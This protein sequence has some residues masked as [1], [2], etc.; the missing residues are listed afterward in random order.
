MSSIFTWQEVMLKISKYANI[1]LMNIKK[2]SM[3]R[4]VNVSWGI[5][6]LCCTLI[7]IAIEI[8][9]PYFFLRDDNADSFIADYTYGINCISSGRFPF[10]CFNEFG[11]QRFFAAGQTGIFNPLVYFAFMTSNLICGKPDMLMDILAYLSIIIGCTAAFFLLKKLGCSDLPA[12]IGAIAWNFNAYNIWEGTSWMIIIY[13]TSVFPIIL[14]TSL[15]LLERPGIPS[16]VLAIIPRVY[17]FYLGHPQFFIFA[18]IFDCIFIGMLCLLRNP[19]N[20]LFS[21]L[22]LIKN[23]L[24]VYV[25]TT[26][27]VLP[28][29]IPE[30]QYTLLSNSYGSAGTTED[31]LREM[32]FDQK[33]FLFPFL[34]TEDNYCY[35][36][37][38]FIGYLLSAFLIAGFFLLIFMFLEESLIKFKPLKAVMIS[39]L[40]CIAI[41]YFLL[42][43]H[44][45]LKLVSYIPILNRFQY[46][47]RLNIFF[48]AFEVIFSC[49]SM[50]VVISLLKEKLEKHISANPRLPAIA[51]RF[52]IGLEVIAFSLL[53]TLTPHLGRGPL[54]DTSELYDYEF[55][56]QFSDGRYLTV[57]Y[58]VYEESINRETHNLSENLNYNLAKLYGINNISGYAGVLNYGNVIRYNDC[59]GHMYAIIGSIHEYYPGLVEQMREQSVSWYIINP[60]N[61][62]E[63]EPAFL[64][65][66]MKYISET[67][68]SV[69]Y[70]DPYFQPLA[71][72]LNSNAVS[73]IQD[74]NSLVLHTNSEF[75]GGKVTLNYAYD[76]NFR[77]YIDGRPVAI[78]D[79]PMNWQYHIECPPGEH[80]IIIQYEDPTFVICCI[81]TAEYIVF[82]SIAVYAHKKIR[83]R[84]LNAEA[85]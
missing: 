33:T 42:F 13:T 5:A 21:I 41:G 46:Y 12:I 3:N 79:E 85:Q 61:R 77:C 14:L 32:W 7:F 1:L 43:N 40:P 19:G 22:R 45:V 2:H 72:D 83:E 52:V 6:L 69:I 50:T 67:D 47:H 75:P 70:Y 23:Y 60:E 68:H 26:F 11:G 78:Y 37:P 74:I 9:Y 81:I 82:A 34:Y 27:L 64:S 84:K 56:S 63:Y 66:G 4:N 36:Y 71:Y 48:S 39:A 59:F 31:I 29:L 28:L 18:A 10:Y 17:L 62:Y 15:C 65:Y 54:Y 53:Y 44:D 49:I 24:I 73:L 30:Y 16:L 58:I 80:E 8:R 57:G 35:F 20:K 38:P 51:F 55:A 25:S 76:P